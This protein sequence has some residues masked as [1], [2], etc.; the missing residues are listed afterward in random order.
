MKAENQYIE[1]YEQCK[2][3]ISANSNEILNAVR[4]EAM[5]TF[6][7]K[8]FPTQ[9]CEM[10]RY[11]HVAPLFAP[12][13]GMNLLRKKPSLNPFQAFTCDVPKLTSTLFFVVNDT[14]FD[15]VPIPH[16]LSQG[17][18]AGGLCQLVTQYPE[19][20]GKYY[21]QLAN[22]AK[23]AITAFNTAFVQDGF[24]VYIPKNTI[25]DKPIQLVNILRARKEMLVNRRLLII[26]EDGASAQLLLC[27][28]TLNQISS[29]STQ[30][31]EVFVGENAN[32][33]LY[34]LEETTA[35]NIRFNSIYVQ[36]KRNSNVCI[37][38]NTLT[39]GITRNTIEVNLEGEGANVDLSGIAIQ[40]GN[41]H[42]DNH[43]Y[44]NHAVSHCTSKELYKY[45]LDEKSVGAFSGRVVVRP[46]AQ[47]TISEQKN[48]NLCVTDEARMYTQPQLEIYADDV[49]C[50]HGATVGQLDQ[51][52]LFY[53]QQRGISPNEATM[54][55]MFAFVNEV[56]DK[57]SLSA[58]R[59]RL[60]LLVEKRFRG[61]LGRCT[62]CM[63]RK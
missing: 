46:D 20:F 14:F 5:S 6:K 63:V 58:L 54:L 60:H 51:N 22:T 28:H 1:L 17:V 18:L 41:Q 33:K 15:K 55:L 62:T 48:S 8:G 26:L 49:K 59:E 31:V 61:E 57:V 47:K 34:D 36:Q 25:L 30:V 21:N 3:I 40:D 10:F 29:L 13:Y 27:D 39:N 16:D 42:V 2:D 19:V 32:F 53:M 50:S 44:V 37:N 56:V 45:V 43:I 35:N 12:N 7:K 24:C 9:K 23:H 11:T 38:G 52:A 4:D